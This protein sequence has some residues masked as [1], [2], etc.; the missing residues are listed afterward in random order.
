[1]ASSSSNITLK[2]DMLKIDSG[3]LQSSGA[4]AIQPYT[5]SATIGVGA[6]SGTL[7]LPQSYFWNG[8][9][10]NFKNGFSGIAIGRADGTGAID[11]NGLS[12]SDPLTLFGG[13][14]V[15]ATLAG[16]IANAGSGTA[17]GSL[18]VKVGGDISS[19][20]AITTQNQA[21][22]FN[23]DSDTSGAGAIAL[24]AGSSIASNGGNVT[25]GGGAD[26]TQ[27]AATGTA[28]GV[29]LNSGA[30]IDAGA[31][32]FPWSARAAPPIPTPA[33]TSISALPSRPQ[34]TAASPSPAP[35]VRPGPTATA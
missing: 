9:S 11:V 29:A 35:A 8:S 21:V 16:T 3:L 15:N 20:A 27:D 24:N 13:A 14:G 17:S 33:S 19:T 12:F 34:A 2:T 5:A 10:G 4:L 30:T 32:T 25:L 31:A 23:A 6:G 26:P 1:M 7:S 28:F 18:T 22:L